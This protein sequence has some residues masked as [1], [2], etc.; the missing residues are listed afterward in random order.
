[1]LPLAAAHAQ[2]IRFRA[3]QDRVTVPIN[4]TDSTVVTN[5]VKLTGVN[6][7]GATLSVIGLPAGAG[8]TI[9]VNPAT[10]NN[11]PIN[12]TIN[13]TNIPQGEYTFFLQ[14]TGQ[15]TNSL[16]LSNV[17]AYVLQAGHIW[18]GTTNAVGDG[19]SSWTDGSKW[20]G[21]VAGAG[22]DVFITDLGGQTNNTF[23]VPSTSTN[24][25]VSITL[26][27][28][29]TI[30]SLRFGPTTN[31]TRF[32]SIQINPGNTLSITDSKGF[33]FLRDYISEIAALGAAPVL[34]FVGGGNLV[35]TNPSANFAL[36][37]DNQVQMTNDM[38]GLA[39]FSATVNRF[40]LGDYTAWP[41]FFNY[42]DDNAIGG[43]PRRF[44]PNV[45]F[46]QTNVLKAFYVDPNNYTNA[47]D[48]KFAFSYCNSEIAGTTTQPMLNLGISN[49]FLMDAVN[50]VGGNQ[51]GNMRF[52]PIY[53][54]SAPIAI[55]RST[56]GGRMSLFSVADAGGTNGENTNVKTPLGVDF[57][58]FGGKL[59][60]LAD[61]LYI[62]RDRKL[63]VGGQNPNYQG[64]LFMSQGTID[65]NTMTLGFQEYSGQTNAV[66]FNGY[67]EGRLTATNSGAGT[68]LIIVRKNLTLGYGTQTDVNGVG[69]GSNTTWGQVILSGSNTT[70]MVSN[71]LIGDPVHT[72]KNNSIEVNSNAT[73]VV[74]NSIGSAAQSLDNLTYRDSTLTLN[75]DLNRSTA[76]VFTTNLT[77]AGSNTIRIASIKNLGSLSGPVKLIQF[78]A[79]NGSFQGLIMPPGLGGALLTTNNFG[80]FL[81]ILT[82]TPKLVVWRGYSS[83]DWDLTTKNWLDVSTGLHTNFSNG[84]LVR[85]DDDAGTPKT[86][87]LAGPVDI[88]PGSIS[89]TNNS[90]AYVIDGVSGG[91]IQG[92]ANLVKWGS[93]P[94][95]ID[96]ITTLTVQLNQGSLIGGNFGA[97]VVGSVTLAAGT[98]MDFTGNLLAGINCAG[99]ASLA[100]D[101]SGTLN[102]VG[103]GIVTNNGNYSGPFITSDGSLLVNNSTYLNGGNSTIVSNATVINNGNFHGVTLSVSGTLK[104]MA[105]GTIYMNGDTVTGTRGLTINNGGTFIPGGN[106]IGTTVVAPETGSP[107]NFPG[108]VLFSTGST[109]I[110]KVNPTAPANTLLESAY[111]GLGPNQNTKQFNGGTI[112]MSNVTLNAFA[113]G[114]SFKLFQYYAGGDAFTAGTNTA[115]SYPIM[116]P[117]TPGPGLAWDLS[118]LLPADGGSAGE[119]LAGVIGVRSVATTPT[120]VI[121][122]PIFAVNTGTNGIGTNV[123]ASQ[124]SWPSNYIGWKLQQQ[125]SDI[126]ISTNWTTIVD[127]SFTNYY[128][129]TNVIN[130]TNNNSVFF[131]MV[132]P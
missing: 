13:T 47:D 5:Q 72:S 28:D 104:D 27:G 19:P 89:M 124:L 85:F 21:G 78:S 54:N 55:F 91:D 22:D 93:Q 16:P 80:I 90:S 71:V 25:L 102:L 120:N 128:V 132:A 35:V 56:N 33:R 106:G 11:T 1:L 12:I 65:V 94:L 131:R 50:F 73:F 6:P 39:N 74:S 75:L 101:S 82:N 118:G 43:I 62:G 115:N 23:I 103:S 37:I 52:N 31:Q 51:Q 97:G 40:A 121:L 17:W 26:S 116:V 14:G 15:D 44:L 114:Q 59:D 76:Y 8:A 29:T 126:G 96:G 84:D 69:S 38:T 46:A 130:P 88:I 108:R 64:F 34:S 123:I 30:G 99:V 60:L 45:Y 67:C 83:S 98:T 95:Q 109:N 24:P 4:S 32:H 112:V 63:I 57:A 49:I 79:G 48:R 9:D 18:N 70:M 3:G 122:N 111:M 87:H 61:R 113:P 81:T 92:S 20:L 105:A 7:S 86:V 125:I 10:S 129:I 42:N 36:L 127:A 41:N 53:S 100:G 2:F 77:T 119:T 117:E 110:F 66:T 107:N 58:S 68:S